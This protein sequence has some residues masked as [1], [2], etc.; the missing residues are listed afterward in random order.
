MFIPQSYRDSN[1][2]W[3]NTTNIHQTVLIDRQRILQNFKKV[4]DFKVYSSFNV[5]KSIIN[6]K[7]SIF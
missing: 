4:E 7:E 5:V 6:L 1:G 3:F 2:N